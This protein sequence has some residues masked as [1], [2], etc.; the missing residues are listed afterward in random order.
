MMY[1]MVPF[2]VTLSDPNL[3]FK[4]TGLVQM[5][6]RIVCAADARSVAI[7]KFLLLSGVPALVYGQTIIFRCTM[8]RSLPVS[9]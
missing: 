8:L 9:V 5:R 1:P 4:V 3:D 2:P 7:A 6:R